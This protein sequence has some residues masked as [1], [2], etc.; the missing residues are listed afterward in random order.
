[1]LPATTH[2]DPDRWMLIQRTGKAKGCNQETK[3]NDF[4]NSYFTDLAG[5]SPLEV[6]SSRGV[7]W[8]HP[9]GMQPEN[10]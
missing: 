3:R 7:G 4:H 2:V 9:D 1:M 8:W 6:A 10:V 5:K